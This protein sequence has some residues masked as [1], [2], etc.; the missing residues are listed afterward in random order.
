MEEEG[1]GDATAPRCKVLHTGVGG[2]GRVWRIWTGLRD[3]GG[4]E[5][6]RA[7]G[8]EGERAILLLLAIE[9]SSDRASMAKALRGEGLRG[10][11]ARR[12]SGSITQWLRDLSS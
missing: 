3:S 2:E 9:S 6:R 7:G 5:G 8:K 4:Q 1:I 12:L 10:S 11:R